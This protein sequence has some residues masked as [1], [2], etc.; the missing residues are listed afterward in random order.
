MLEEKQYV[1]KFYEMWNKV[2]QLMIKD[3]DVAVVHDDKY[4]PP[5]IKSYG[6]EIKTDFHNDGLPPEKTHIHKNSIQF[7]RLI[8]H[9]ILK[10][11]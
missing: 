8:E 4:I 10:H 11:F 6:N 5:K 2:K 3:I 7:T 1:R 9:I